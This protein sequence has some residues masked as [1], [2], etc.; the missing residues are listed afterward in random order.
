MVLMEGGGCKQTHLSG[1]RERGL[2][3]GCDWCKCEDDK[4]TFEQT[5]FKVTTLNY[6]NIKGEI[7]HAYHFYSVSEDVH[8]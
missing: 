8:S 7:E 3:D 6:L 5:Q 2:G 1:M 4:A